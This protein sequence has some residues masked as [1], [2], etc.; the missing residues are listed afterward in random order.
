MLQY[1]WERGAQGKDLPIPGRKQAQ[2]SCM[3]KRYLPGYCLFGWEAGGEGEVCGE[4][5]HQSCTPTGFTVRL[6]PVG[7]IF[8]RD[9]KTGIYIATLKINGKSIESVK[10]TLL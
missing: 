1:I 8:I 4:V 2:C 7:I 9:W 3:A 6:A 5:G 10:F